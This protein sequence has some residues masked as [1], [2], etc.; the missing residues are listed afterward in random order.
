MAQVRKQYH[1]RPSPNGFFAWDV[2]RLIALS[3]GL[4]VFDLSLDSIAEIDELW[5]FQTETDRPTPRAIAGHL[6]L[7]M[8]A[9][10]AYPIILCPQGR[11]MDGMHRVLKSLASGASSINAV[12]LPDMPEPDHTDIDPADL[13]G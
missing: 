4:P 12:Q 9:D 1:F 7:M 8:E 3:E 5:W 2:S 6:R 11:L 10:A 13:G